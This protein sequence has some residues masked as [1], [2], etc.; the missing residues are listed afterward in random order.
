MDGADEANSGPERGDSD[1]SSRKTTNSAATTSTSVA[2]SPAPSGRFRGDTEIESLYLFAEHKFGVD[3]QHD[4]ALLEGGRTFCKHIERCQLTCSGVHPNDPDAFLL[5]ASA[6]EDPEL[7]TLPRRDISSV[8]PTCAAVVDGDGDG[9]SHNIDENEVGAEQSSSSSFCCGT[10][11]SI[12]GAAVKHLFFDSGPLTLGSAHGLRQFFPNL[13]SFQ[14]T[15]SDGYHS[16]GDWSALAELKQLRKLTWDMGGTHQGESV[17]QLTTG[18]LPLKGTLQ[19]LELG[20]FRTGDRAILR[21]YE[22]LTNLRYLCHVGDIGEAD[23]SSSRDN[24]Q[25][26]RQQTLDLSNLAELR[27]LKIS[28][29]G[30]RQ[31][32]ATTLLG[33][34]AALA[35]LQSAGMD[36]SA[37]RPT[38][39]VA[40][41]IRVG[42]DFRFGVGDSALLLHLKTLQFTRCTILSVPRFSP[43]PPKLG[44]RQQYAVCAARYSVLEHDVTDSVDFSAGFP[45]ESWRLFRADLFASDVA[46]P[47]TKKR[48]V[49]ARGQHVTTSAGEGERYFQE[50]E[51]GATSH[52]PER[53]GLRRDNLER[54]VFWFDGYECE[55]EHPY[56]ISR[57]GADDSCC[58]ET[59]G[60]AHPDYHALFDVGGR[61]IWNHRLPRR[62][63]FNTAYGDT[64]DAV[65]E[66]L[67]KE[68]TGGCAPFT[69]YKTCGELLR[70]EASSELSAYRKK[71]KESLAREFSSGECAI[72][73][74]EVVPSV[75]DR[76]KLLTSG[77]STSRSTVQLQAAQ[78]RHAPPAGACK[79]CCNLVDLTEDPDYPLTRPEAGTASFE[80]AGEDSTFLFRHHLEHDPA[81]LAAL[82]DY[83]EALLAEL[84]GAELSTL[85]RALLAG[86]RWT[87]CLY[88][89][90]WEP[91]TSAW[92]YGDKLAEL[93]KSLDEQ[94]SD[95]QNASVLSEEMDIMK[96]ELS[97]T[98]SLS[99]IIRIG[100]GFGSLMTGLPALYGGRCSWQDCLPR[101]LHSLAAETGPFLSSFVIGGESAEKKTKR[102]Y[103]QNEYADASP[104]TQLGVL[105]EADGTRLRLHSLYH[106]HKST[107]P[108]GNESWNPR[109]SSALA[110]F[111]W[112]DFFAKC[113]LLRFAQLDGCPTF[114]DDALTT[115]ATAC[116][117][118]EQLYVS[119]PPPPD[120]TALYLD[121][122]AALWTG[123]DVSSA[124]VEEL[125]LRNK[126]FRVTNNSTEDEA[127]VSGSYFPRLTAAWLFDIHVRKKV[128]EGEKQ[129]LNR[130]SFLKELRE[131]R[132]H[133]VAFG[134][135]ASR[136]RLKYNFVLRDEDEGIFEDEYDCNEDQ[137]EQDNYEGRACASVTVPQC[138]ICLQRLYPKMLSSA[139]VSG[140]PATSF[141]NPSGAPAIDASDANPNGEGRL[142]APGAAATDEKNGAGSD[143]V[144]PSAGR[145]GPPTVCSPV[146][147][148]Q[149]RAAPVSARRL[150][151]G[152]RRVCEIAECGHQFHMECLAKWE[153]STC[154]V[155]RG[156]AGERHR[157]AA[158]VLPLGAKLRTTWPS[159]AKNSICRVQGLQKRPD[160]NGQEVAVR[161]F[162]FRTD[163]YVCDLIFS[164]ATVDRCALTL[165]ESNLSLLHAVRFTLAELQSWVD[166]CAPGQR[167]CVPSGI[168][169]ADEHK[170]SRPE[171][172]NVN[173][174]GNS[175][176]S[177]H[178]HLLVNKPISLCGTKLSA[179]GRGTTTHTT[180]LFPV[181]FDPAEALGGNILCVDMRIQAPV[182]VR[183][184]GLR[185]Y[186][187]SVQ[188]LACLLRRCEIRFALRYGLIADQ[189]CAVKEC[190]IAQCY[191]GAI[192]EKA[193]VKVRRL[194]TNNY[195]Q[196]DWW[197]IERWQ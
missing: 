59:E 38:N 128:I 26:E 10:P 39:V 129:E 137:D 92:L 159:L 47:W 186:G 19:H 190:Q 28:G 46:S 144:A 5:V 115:L 170:G 76:D 147:E 141:L 133:F 196:N 14:Y 174:D 65:F 184:R 191:S 112:K 158:R 30:N 142:S 44:K 68:R 131:A 54:R 130:K 63:L 69:A 62:L 60:R 77:H 107:Y 105:Q 99:L 180:L 135:G 193:G 1:T 67:W 87:R 109:D 103:Y 80:A 119:G 123:V 51:V 12:S 183:G 16:C 53:S 150:I 91:Q 126:P 188:C 2:Q 88:F 152:R 86:T 94:Q 175:E 110:G 64:R 118:L 9:D 72:A 4:Q 106:L 33:H 164:D 167:L 57:S 37:L 52:G 41:W 139:V 98:S 101:F 78:T 3:E 104:R 75:K 55:G 165:K 29:G 70:R 176:N 173:P 120:S 24:L 20:D 36:T 48:F 172:V 127:P 132:P 31:Q 17:D 66:E 11:E 182:E 171:A 138:K 151:C 34:D 194:G 89:F 83:R 185:K 23:Y 117:L 121:P 163:R 116:P 122:G 45:A 18:I 187:V 108:G 162:D 111:E 96:A 179:P 21:M 50:G 13:L 93:R 49:S 156:P 113:P 79:P 149:H 114:N 145:G 73:V 25:Q 195:I 82:N 27:V 15:C 134:C 90:S 7:A 56:P 160:L 124:C 181:L 43:R 189:N 140:A 100:D 61:T 136:D 178:P 95:L 84:T 153:E 97:S 125:F 85:Q 146:D 71:L 169:V 157:R 102:N 22:R 6:A 155:C 192:F 40:D 197:M 154:P 148:E 161:H 35:L 143:V 81:T 166:R 8:W 58:V 32:F 42:H 168:F 74:G 177:G